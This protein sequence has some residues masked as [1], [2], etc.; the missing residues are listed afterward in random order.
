MHQKAKPSPPKKLEGF[1]GGRKF[2]SD[3]AEHTE[4]PG[5]ATGL[6][7]TATGGDILFVEASISQGTGQLILTGQLGDIMKE[8]AQAALS[9][10][11]SQADELAIPQ[12]AFRH[13]DV[14]VH[15]PAGAV[16]KDGPSA[17][18][19]I[20]SA[21]VSIFTQRR[22]AHDVAMTGEITLRGL[23]L[24]VG[25]IKEKV[26]AA[27]RAGIKRV[28]L[29]HKNEKDIKEIKEKALDGLDIQYVKRV[30]DALL[31]NLEKNAV[32]D[33]AVLF[34]HAESNGKPADPLVPEESSPPPLQP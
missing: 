22:V 8:S 32:T 5:V 21:L 16:P 14:H 13:W 4:V 28:L 34:A 31:M 19:A 29:P 25:G 15:V 12:Y 20:L 6:A 33:P 27:R 23:V 17:G 30:G 2:F 26:L 1:L 9:Y 18:I 3:V 10:V 11:K 24:P 7:W